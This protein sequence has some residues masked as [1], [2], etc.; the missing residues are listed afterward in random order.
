MTWGD[1][2]AGASTRLAGAGLDDPRRE[3]WALISALLG[4]NA[5]HH[6]MLSAPVPADQLARLDG[7]LAARAAR[8]P[9]SQIIGR[10]AFWKHDFRVTRDTLDPRP[11]TESLIEAALK[12]PWRSVLDLGTGTGAILISLLAERS[13]ARGLGT[14]LSE[15]ALDVARDNAARIGVDAAFQRADWFQGVAGRFDLIVSNPPYIAQSEMPDLSPEVREW[16]PHSA[17][18]DF[19]DGL[20]AYR[21][22]AAGARTHLVPGGH[23]LVEIGWQQ[24]R[25]VAAIFADAGAEVAVLPDLDGRDRVVRALFPASLA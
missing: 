3:A 5:R 4:S 6:I 14:D 7:M 11:E 19:G 23:V 12:L 1:W 17:L 15:S 18:T 8:Q 21:A 13:G 22:I 24:G 25:D 16:E 20:S 2:L 10:R 9:L